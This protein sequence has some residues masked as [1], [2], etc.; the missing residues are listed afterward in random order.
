MSV[1]SQNLIRVKVIK[2]VKKHNR[3]RMQEK[4]IIDLNG[5]DLQ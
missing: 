2:M 3:K 5:N 4:T 1:L